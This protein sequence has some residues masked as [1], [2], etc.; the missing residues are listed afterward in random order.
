VT[1]DVSR[2]PPIRFGVF[3]LDSESGELRKSGVLIHLRPQPAKI[4][5]LLAG[6]PGQLVTREEIRQHVWGDG[7]L[8]DSEQGL[9]HC[10]QHIRAAL[11]DDAEVARYI[12]T[13][14]QRGYR[15]I[16]PVDGH[17]AFV[18]SAAA[19]G[20]S[21]DGG[22]EAVGERLRT[23]PSLGPQGTADPGIEVGES[24]VQPA[25]GGT[26]FRG[27]SQRWLLSFGTMVLVTGVLIGAGLMWQLRPAP[28]ASVVRS[29]IKLEPGQC[30]DGLRYPGFMRP[31]RTAMVLSADGRFIVYSAVAENAAPEARGQLYLR[32]MDQPTA[33]AIPG[34]EGG[35]SPFLSPD[36]RW[37]GFWAGGKLM[38]APIDGGVPVTLCDVQTPFGATWGFDNRIVFSPGEGAGLSVVATDGGKPEVLTV[39]DKPRQ[40]SDHRLPHFLPGGKGVL[41]TVMREPWDLEPRV[42]VLQGKTR[43]WRHLLDDAADARYVPTGHL[44]FLRQGTLMAVPFDPDRLEV[45]GQPVP[46]I[47]GLMQALN[48]LHS[49]FIT[50]A[51]QFSIS[52]S[53]GLVYAPGGITPDLE[54]SLVWVDRKGTL[55]PALPFKGPFNAPRLSPDGRRVAYTLRGREFRAWEYD[56]VRGIATRLTVGG[57][58]NYVTWTPDGKRA[59]FDW[60]KPGGLPNLYWQPADESLPME[61]LTTSEHRQFPGSWSPD[62]T[63]LAFVE[64]FPD[65][66]FETLLLDVRRR[67]VTPFLN[68]H[69]NLEG[70]PEFSPDGRWLAYASDESGRTE[71]YV[72]PFPGPGGKWQISHE[73]GSEPLWARTGKQLF[74][75]WG[76]QVWAVDV[77]TGPALGAGKPRLLFEQP[78][79]GSS[80]PLRR[81]DLSLDQR[82][83]L[84]VKLDDRKPAPVTELI[85]V[86]NWF[87]ELKRLA[88][89]GSK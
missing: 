17:L 18:P 56:L 63:T 38:K 26:L 8:V 86:Q 32:W 67:R 22:P 2:R 46:L 50:A 41:F 33:K 20:R 4:L 11:G 77:Q 65:S 87:E 5:V 80:I 57:K 58:A 21:G 53:G 44:I 23:Q 82:R 10:I 72:R 84:M 52:R 45:T 66:G 37:V 6:R 70:Y 3:E 55:Q 78:G 12:Q 64:W 24:V 31:T 83:F 35:I 40:E 85:L 7:T 30:L 60:W 9:N 14:P 54:N 34:T 48:T 49:G 88:P 16:A 79:F 81:W 74:Y 13:L 76:D 25:A 51:G 29:V 28:A 43:R 73:G 68:S 39:P 71:V 59:A 42:A 1:G 19:E 15:F 62:G 36:D 75:R 47:V 27:F 69:V 89:S 61:R